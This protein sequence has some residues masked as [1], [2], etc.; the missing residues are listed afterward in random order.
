MIYYKYK[1]GGIYNDNIIKYLLFLLHVLD[2]L[3]L[4]QNI[5]EIYI[6]K[7]S[8]L[9]FVMILLSLFTIISSGCGLIKS[10]EYCSVS[11]CHK[12]I[13]SKSNYCV[14]HKC[15]NHNCDNK[16]IQSY[17]YCMECIERAHNK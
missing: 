17:S 13:F 16:A 3:I 11:G 2:K 8:Y 4:T 7:K 14:E 10:V 12:E 15:Y 1:K 6:M 5:K 9:I